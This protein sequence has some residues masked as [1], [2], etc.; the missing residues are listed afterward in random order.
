MVQENENTDAGLVAVR[1]VTEEGLLRGAPPRVLAN[2]M[3]NIAHHEAAHVFAALHFGF[4]LK[5]LA[6]ELQGAR[7]GLT[8]FHHGEDLVADGASGSRSRAEEAIVVLL[9][10]AAAVRKLRHSYEAGCGLNE[11]DYAQAKRLIEALTPPTNDEDLPWHDT[12]YPWWSEAN[13]GD[14]EQISYLRVLEFR[15]ERL[16]SQHWRVI[17]RLAI[18]LACC[19]R[20]AADQAREI[21]HG[22]RG[23]ARGRARAH[24]W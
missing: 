21:I 5:P 14:T 3:T 12:A 16:V 8:H 7:G 13:G 19:G 10:G 9:A 22:G 24:A 6:A 15:A 2:R 1:F 11:K 23:A 18:R 17:R 4:Q 20:L